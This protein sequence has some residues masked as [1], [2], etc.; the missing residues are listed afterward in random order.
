M[1]RSY[2]FSVPSY[3][4]AMFRYSV[5]QTMAMIEYK[6]ENSA[7]EHTRQVISISGPHSEKSTMVLSNFTSGGFNI[8]YI[9][10]VVDRV[11]S[12]LSKEVSIRV[13]SRVNRRS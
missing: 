12:V 3:D 2:A 13:K 8:I 6:N 7:V 1:C 4:I 11:C 10:V 9:R 5:I